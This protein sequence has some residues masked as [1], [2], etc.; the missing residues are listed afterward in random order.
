MSVSVWVEAVQCDQ[1][2]VSHTPSVLAGKQ[3][4]G[5]VCQLRTGG[6]ETEGNCRPLGKINT[7]KKQNFAES[8]V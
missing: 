3:E 8:N 6:G 7:K 4:V 2:W 5:G 1:D